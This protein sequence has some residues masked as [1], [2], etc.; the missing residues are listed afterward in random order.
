[1]L[2]CFLKTWV[3]F[4]CI[5]LFPL[6]QC[7]SVGI[8]HRRHHLC[9]GMFQFCQKYVTVSE[10]LKEELDKYYI[11]GLQDP[12]DGSKVV[13][14]WK[15]HEKSVLYSIYTHIQYTVQQCSSVLLYFFFKGIIP[16][17]QYVWKLS[18]LHQNNLEGCPALHTIGKLILNDL[19]RYTV[20]YTK[21]PFCATIILHMCA[22]ALFKRVQQ[23]W[24]VQIHCPWN[25]MTHTHKHT[26]SPCRTVC[27]QSAAAQLWSSKKSER[28]SRK[29]SATVGD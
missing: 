6:S 25:L 14:L 8:T 15:T 20:Q 9:T 2:V 24:T 7:A 23:P 4:S 12:G 5:H 13:W 19:P 1:M 17:S 29:T 16:Y 26:T 18:I 11:K 10:F 21:I 22:Y 27:L 3:M 28:T